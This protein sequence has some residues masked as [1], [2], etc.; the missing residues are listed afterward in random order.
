MSERV[1][2]ALE[3][4]NFCFVSL[5]NTYSKLKRC[6]DNIYIIRLIFTALPQ[7]EKSIRARNVAIQAGLRSKRA[8]MERDFKKRARII[9][10]ELTCNTVDHK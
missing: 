2:R 7:D 5:W 8:E 1:N 6:K 9:F 4:E 10:M 3:S